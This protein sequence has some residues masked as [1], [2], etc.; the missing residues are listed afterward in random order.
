MSWRGQKI[1]VAWGL[2]LA[3]GGAGCQDQRFVIGNL[4]SGQGGGAPE[5][6]MFEAPAAVAELNSEAREEDPTLTGDLL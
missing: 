1:A 2:W 6:P 5:R 3:L 4:M